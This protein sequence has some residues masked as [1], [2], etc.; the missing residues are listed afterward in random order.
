MSWT[1]ECYSANAG[2]ILIERND[3]RRGGERR[4]MHWWNNS[5]IGAKW[6]S[7]ASMDRLCRVAQ[8]YATRIRLERDGWEASGE[9]EALR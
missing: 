1:I 2:S 9:D 7:L 6:I 3:A 8:K 4:T 5:P